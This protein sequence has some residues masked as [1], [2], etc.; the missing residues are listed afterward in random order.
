M[1]AVK[2]QVNILREISHLT[3]LKSEAGIPKSE[4][5]G[6]NSE[7][8]S[9]SSAFA[10]LQL[11]FLLLSIPLRTVSARFGL[12]HLNSIYIFYRASLVES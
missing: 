2:I 10:V 7:V 8:E 9:P 6:R 3:Y 4:V 11:Y 1:S 12:A 5:G